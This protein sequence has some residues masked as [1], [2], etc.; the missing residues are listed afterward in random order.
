MRNKGSGRERKRGSK[1]NRKG[2]ITVLKKALE[3]TEKIVMKKHAL[4][5]G[6]LKSETP[7]DNKTENLPIY[8]HYISIKQSK[9][10]AWVMI[11]HQLQLHII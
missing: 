11:L 4:N 1:K 3:R 2:K 8:H 10:A 7:R 9:K 5:K 6:K